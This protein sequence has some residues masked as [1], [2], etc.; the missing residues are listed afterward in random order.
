MI[1]KDRGAA[2]P[3][4]SATLAVG[5]VL[6]LGLLFSLRPADPALAN[7][8]EAA[9]QHAALVAQAS[10]TADA[11]Q[12]LEDQLRTALDA[13]RDGAAAV[14]GG[15]DP[16]GPRF[17]AAADAAAADAVAAAAEPLRD[18]HAAL[19]NLRGLSSLTRASDPASLAL[20][21]SDLTGLEQQLRATAAAGDQFAA[22]RRDTEQV[23]DRM[24]VALAATEAADPR[25]ALAAA[26]DGE[27][28]LRAVRPWEAQMSTL[29]VWTDTVDGILSALADLARATTAHDAAAA[30]SAR[31]A[32]EAAAAGA[33]RADRARAIAISEGAG[34]VSAPALEG[35]AD[36]MER[37]QRARAGVS[38]LAPS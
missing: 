34:K 35:L 18:A 21:R 7:P 31:S 2:R 36:A 13:A 29:S 10:R 5:A 25:S 1:G 23:L 16:P 28:R 20:T 26:N 32:Y 27:E 3:W 37:V 8:A 6:L 9:H 17:L 33:S 12:R 11:L 24:R 4:T 15:E 19:E 22:F 14:V 38:S 30:A